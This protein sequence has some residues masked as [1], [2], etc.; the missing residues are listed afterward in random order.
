MR[1]PALLTAPLVLGVALTSI[2]MARHAG[3]DRP[4]PK[5]ARPDAGLFDPVDGLFKRGPLEERTLV[6]SFDDG[7]HP[8]SCEPLLDKLRELDVKATFFV[9]GERVQGPTRPRAPDDCRGS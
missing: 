7:P 5:G 2:C 1:F 4:L 9:V 8:E 3:S 6:L